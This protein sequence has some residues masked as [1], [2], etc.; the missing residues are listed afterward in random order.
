MRERRVGEVVAEPRAE[1]GSEIVAWV[2][3]WN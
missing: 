3:R 2:L 1:A